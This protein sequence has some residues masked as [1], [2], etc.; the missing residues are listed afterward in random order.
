MSER[1]PALPAGDDIARRLP[2]FLQAAA[3]EPF[4]YGRSDCSMVLANWVL[5][6]TG[7]DPAAE[8]RGA[9]GD[10]EGWRA[11]VQEAGGLIVL[12]RRLALLAG[13]HPIEPAAAAIGDIA[14]VEIAS[15][16]REGVPFHAGAICSGHNP[17]GPVDA[18]KP[19]WV[20]KLS[21]GI[22]RLQATPLAAWGF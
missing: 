5:E 14:V 9:Y 18:G 11:L 15:L 4:V 12:V 2:A 17:P 13:L 7:R 8:L 22:S 16:A 3:G 1:L 10:D 19:K 21:R 6:I 20:T